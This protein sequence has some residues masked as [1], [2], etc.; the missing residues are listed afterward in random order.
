MAEPPADR[1]LEVLLDSLRRSRGFDF[2]GYKR[3][4]LTRRIDKR[5]QTAGVDGY[6]SYLDYLEVDPEEF[7][8]LFNTILV[9]VTSFFRDPPAW[10]YLSAEALPRLLADKDDSEPIRI[11]SAGCASGEEAYTL[12]MVAAEALGPDAVRERVKIYAP[13]STRRRSPRP[14]RP[15][16]RPSGWKGSRR[17]CWSATS[18][19]TGTA[20][21]SPRSCAGRSSSAATT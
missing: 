10:D 14:A 6:L 21:S 18:R 17:S 12:A 3:T 19:A 13:T 4:S 8:Q 1:D 2:T 20:T 9:N 7:T 5:M 16:M 11:W 15:G